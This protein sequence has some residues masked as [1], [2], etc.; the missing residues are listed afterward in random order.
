MTRLPLEGIRAVDLSIHLATPLLGRLLASLGAE[1]I[2]VETWDIDDYGRQSAMSPHLPGGFHTDISSGVRNT[3]MDFRIPG[4]REKFGDLIRKSDLFF[5]SYSPRVLEKYQLNY[6]SLRQVRPDLIYML[7]SGMGAE[8]PYAGWS[9]IG[10]TLQAICGASDFSRLPGEPP[11]YSDSVFNDWLSPYHRITLLLGAIEHRRQTGEGLFI[12][13]PLL[14]AGLPL[15]GPYILDYMVNGHVTSAMG[16]SSPFAAPHA[17]YPAAGDDRWV[18]ITVFS[19]EEWQ[20]FCGALGKPEWSRDP[21]FE[22]VIDRLRHEEELDSLISQ[23]T[24][25]RDAREIVQLLREAGVIAGLV[26]KGED[27]SEDPHLKER[28][29]YVE[30]PYYPPPQVAG[31]A[32]DGTTTAMRLPLRFSSFQIETPPGTRIG[33]DNGYVFGELLG[34]DPD[35][36]RALAGDGPAEEA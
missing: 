16:N 5:T 8:G 20:R 25:E 17:A 26:A 31:K 35:E 7:C 11:L 4:V 6:E 32:A 21:R 23:W 2:R 13:S 22:T 1:V 9:A 34:L 10:H 30:V 28:G 3:T 29:L 14:E 19:E 33:E 12:E 15:L 18:A 24:A 36:I 27:M